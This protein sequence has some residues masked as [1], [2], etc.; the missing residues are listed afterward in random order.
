MLLSDAWRGLVWYQGMQAILVRNSRMEK[1]LHKQLRIQYMVAY[2]R[3]TLPAIQLILSM[4]GIVFLPASLTGVFAS[5]LLYNDVEVMVILSSPHAEYSDFPNVANLIN[6][7]IP[8]DRPLIRPPMVR[9]SFLSD[10][11]MLVVVALSLA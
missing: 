11:L 3:K 6:H 7:N 2:W 8:S 10:V 4:M 1:K 9:D 5:L